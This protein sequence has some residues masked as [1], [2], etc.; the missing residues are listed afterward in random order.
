MIR[1]VAIN[2]LKES[3]VSFLLVSQ[4]PNLERFARLRKVREVLVAW[5]A[6]SRPT[7]PNDRLAAELHDAKDAGHP[8]QV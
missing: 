7:D 3:H 8:F 6:K 5:I 2:C 1:A 4:S